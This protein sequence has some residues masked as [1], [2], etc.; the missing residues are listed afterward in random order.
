MPEY[1]LLVFSAQIVAIFSVLVLGLG[2]LKSDP[3]A[4][5]ARMSLLLSLCIASYL[6][7]SMSLSYI[8]DPFRL[9]PG[10]WWP[11]LVLASTATPGVFM[12]YC[13]YFF[14]DHGKPARSLLGL[15]FF[16][17]SLTLINFQFPSVYSWLAGVAG[18][19]VAIGIL[20]TLPNLIQLLFAALA[21][22]WVARGWREDLVESRRLLRSIVVSVQSVVILVV[23]LM[24]NYVLVNA[25]DQY[26]LMRN[27]IHYGISI[28]SFGALLTVFNFNY[29]PVEKVLNKVVSTED[30]HSQ[31]EALASE[32]VKLNGVL[33]QDKIY[34]EH[35]LTIAKLATVLELPEYRLRA[36]INKHLG[37]RN[38]NALLHEYRIDDACQML[39]Q[40]GDKHLPVLTI[41]L[42]VGYQS[43]TPFNNA[44]KQLKGVT[45][46][47]FRKGA[48]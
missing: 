40:A 28:V 34:R 12:L 30:D 48:H 4:M 10:V 11:L 33:K 2:Y 20:R 22:F 35:G 38:F 43:I 23:L 26:G 42:T 8:P 47:E 32:V 45:P 14:E 21:L 36:L 15:L 9:N 29:G 27:I 19:S 31:D 37:Y 39:A 44:F 13:F 18:E 24:E 46:T 16:S 41:A 25:Q 3:K 17:L 5:S 6:L 7:I 1:V